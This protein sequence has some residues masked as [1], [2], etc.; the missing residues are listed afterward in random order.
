MRKNHGPIYFRVKVGLLPCGHD[1]GT[2]SLEQKKEKSS[3][4]MWKTSTCIITSPC[5][6][7]SS[8]LSILWE[9]EAQ[10]SCSSTARYTQQLTI[11]CSTTVPFLRQL[12]SCARRCNTT[13]AAVRSTSVDCIVVTWGFENCAR[14]GSLNLATP[15]ISQS[16]NL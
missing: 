13:V 9:N 2:E 6:C 15:S 10:R 12:R 4:L 8:C 14:L 16:L 3:T 7:L 5:P 11:R 1:P